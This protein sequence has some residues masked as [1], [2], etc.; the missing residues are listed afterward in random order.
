MSFDADLFRKEFKKCLGYLTPTD[1]EALK[2]WAN[3]N[4]KDIMAA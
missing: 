4:Y 2:V 1:A 3:E